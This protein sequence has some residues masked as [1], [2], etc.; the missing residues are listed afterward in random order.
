MYRLICRTFVFVVLIGLVG[1]GGGNA[2]APTKP[3]VPGTKVKASEL[4]K[5]YSGNVLAADTKYKGKLL[6]V[7]GKFSTSRRIPIVNHYIVQLVA[8]DATNDP[9][10]TFIQCI[11]LKSA[12]ADVANMKEGQIVTF[13][14]ECDGDVTG[15][16]KL[17]NCMVIK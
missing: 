4:L 10:F 7:T 13:E 1:C 3:A 2:P 11:L 8:E 9:T 16:I 15:Q 5:A 12:E 17:S 14:G 6:R